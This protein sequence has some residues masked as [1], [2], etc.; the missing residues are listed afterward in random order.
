MKYSTVA[1]E[2]E[3]ESPWEP[4]HVEQGFKKE[5]STISVF[6]PNNFHQQW[7][8]GTSDDGI[9]KGL[10]YNFPQ[11]KGVACI[12]MSPTPAKTLARN[13]WTKKKVKEYISE[14]ARIPY[15]HHPVYYGGETVFEG[16]DKKS[17]PMN[18][19][20]SIRVIPNPEALWIFVAGGETS[21]MV[22]ARGSPRFLRES[23]VNLVSKKV[24]LPARWDKLVEKYKDI[25]PTYS[26]Y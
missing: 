13:G 25:T 19:E 8:Y 18:P 14:Y 12:M 26:M 5:D 2:N 16:T 21:N 4:L 10:I 23:M 3:E 9:L 15:S 20:D 22:I 7:G 24:E 6:F 11:G 17:M 1:A